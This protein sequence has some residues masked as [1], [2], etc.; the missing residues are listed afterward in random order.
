MF[1]TW[2]KT[3]NIQHKNPT[4]DVTKS[5]LHIYSKSKTPLDRNLN[6]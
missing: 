2:L 1:Q 4:N 3:F 6:K 5:N